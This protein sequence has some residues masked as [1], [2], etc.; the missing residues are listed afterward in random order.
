MR[1][2]LTELTE[3]VDTIERDAALSRK[4]IAIFEEIAAEE[5]RKIAEL[6]DADGPTSRAFEKITDARYTRVD[7]DADDERLFVERADGHSVSP[8]A[9][10]E[11]TSDQLHFATRLS[12][13]EQILE[14]EPGFLLLDDPLVGADPGRLTR[15]F[16]TLSD[17]ADGGWQIVY[18][19]AKEEVWDGMVSTFD[20]PHAEVDSIA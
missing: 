20:L 18:L 2:L 14:A 16:E 5:Q 3:L 17:L 4:A 19:T 6:F 13:A 15:G 10:S 11:G 7:Y 8:T 12:L 9:L 1:S